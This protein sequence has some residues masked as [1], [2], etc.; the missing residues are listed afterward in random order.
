MTDNRHDADSEIVVEILRGAAG[1][2][3]D[4]DVELAERLVVLVGAESRLL[5]AALAA[6]IRDAHRD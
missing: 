1:D 2:S 5:D 3:R 6:L 4:P